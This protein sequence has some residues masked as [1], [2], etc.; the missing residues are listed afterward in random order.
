M[1]KPI[2]DKYKV[3]DSNPITQPQEIDFDKV[4]TL[5]DV[6]VIL[7]ALNLA[8]FPDSPSA[9]IARDYLKETGANNE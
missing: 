3:A 9:H 8:F 2:D 1:T 6:I 5:K 7:K 4:K